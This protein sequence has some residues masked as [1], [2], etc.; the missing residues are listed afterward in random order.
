MD[1]KY[2]GIAGG[3]SSAGQAAPKQ[4]PLGRVF[5]AI[6]TLSAAAELAHN[7]GN[8]LAGSQPENAGKSVNPVGNGLF[9]EL[10]LAADR[11]EAYALSI[12][13]DMQRIQNRL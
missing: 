6:D 5:N 4:Q 10:A 12:I 2:Y 3:M 1:E 7:V 8:S 9:D 13:N 11:I